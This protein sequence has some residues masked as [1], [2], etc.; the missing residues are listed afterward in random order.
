M[1]LSLLK[2]LGAPIFNGPVLATNNHNHNHYFHNNFLQV[3][4]FC[5][6]LLILKG[7]FIP[8]L[9]L[10]NEYHL[11]STQDNGKKQIRDVRFLVPWAPKVSGIPLG[12]SDWSQRPPQPYSSA[13]QTA[14]KITWATVA[15]FHPT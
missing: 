8:V 15:S 11:P 2:T 7:I 3:L 9:Q 1:L 6:H 5:H 4:E 13:L 12:V 10:K 14:S